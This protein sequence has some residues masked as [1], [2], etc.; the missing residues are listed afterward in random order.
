MTGAG[1]CSALATSFQ[2][3]TRGMAAL[4]TPMLTSDCTCSQKTPPHK[5]YKPQHD[6][7]H[8][9]AA[10]VPPPERRPA[11]Q[12]ALYVAPPRLKE[13]NGRIRGVQPRP[14][15]RQ[16]VC[17]W[18]PTPWACIRESWRASEHRLGTQTHAY[19]PMLGPGS[20]ACPFQ[21]PG[22]GRLGLDHPTMGLRRSGA[23]RRLAQTALAA[24]SRCGARSLPFQQSCTVGL[25]Q[26]TCACQKC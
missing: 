12:R 25:S 19:A 26:A 23:P 10:N 3:A 13:Q 17:R 24:L 22:P 15:S 1:P 20:R 9:F 5:S 7:V 6:A 8:K 21:A 11:S 18:K 4:Y 14:T 2:K 16:Q